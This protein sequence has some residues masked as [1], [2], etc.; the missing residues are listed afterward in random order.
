M[1]ATTTHVELTPTATY[2][3]RSAEWVRVSDTDGVLVIRLR[4]TDHGTEEADVYAVEEQRSGHP[5]VREWL[6]TNTIDEGQPD[7]YRVTVGGPRQGCTCRAGLCR[8]GCKHLDS[9]SCLVAIGA[10]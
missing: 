5:S 1:T 10:V 9:M 8:L 2:R 7:S 6:L 4:K 3:H